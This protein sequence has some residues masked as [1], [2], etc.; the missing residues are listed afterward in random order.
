MRLTSFRAE[1]KTP[2]KKC[3]ADDFRDYLFARHE[4][5]PGAFVR[6]TAILGAAHFLS[7]SRCSETAAT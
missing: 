3:T 5:R 6:A 4:T 1:N 7:V 2:W